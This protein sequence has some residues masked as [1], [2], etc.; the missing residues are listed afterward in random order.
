MSQE[1]HRGTPSISTR[2]L[3]RIAKKGVNAGS[4]ARGV[5]QDGLDT[6]ERTYGGAL[7]IEADTGADATTIRR[8]YRARDARGGLTI[9]Y[10]EI[11]NY[12]RRARRAH[13]V[14]TACIRRP[15]VFS[16]RICASLLPVASEM[17]AT[18]IPIRATTLLG[19][20]N[21]VGK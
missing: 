13:A 1:C 21:S 19:G 16:A 8:R 10:L 14:Y 4:V 5:G 2:V 11:I 15:R 3:A 17:H 7:I 6:R 18:I 20:R 9:K 12:T